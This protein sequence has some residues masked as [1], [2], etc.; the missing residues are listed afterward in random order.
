MTQNKK[1]FP[2]ENT[3]IAAPLHEA[4]SKRMRSGVDTKGPKNARQGVPGEGPVRSVGED[5]PV[6]RT[7]PPGLVEDAMSVS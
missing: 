7:E 4:L 2:L 5:E 3:G 6:S 1:G